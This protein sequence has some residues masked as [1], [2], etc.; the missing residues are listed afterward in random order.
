MADNYNELIVGESIESLIENEFLAQANMYS[1]NVGLTSLVVGANGDYT[2]KSSEDLYTNN[3][4]LSKLM[5]AYTE[6]CKGKKTLIFNNGI[7]TS[8]FVY[9]LFRNA[10][11]PIAHLDNTASKKERTQI[12]KWFKETPSAILT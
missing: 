10:G 4:M 11:Y 1:Y 7:N 6:R 12:L 5:E 8:L 3:E 9:D 2:V